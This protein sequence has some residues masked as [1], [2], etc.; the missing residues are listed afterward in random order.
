MWLLNKEVESYKCSSFNNSHIFPP[1]QRL[2]C[3][4]LEAIFSVLNSFLYVKYKIP[5]C[6]INARMCAHCVPSYNQ[7]SYKWSMLF[8]LH[9]SCWTSLAFSYVNVCHR[10]YTTYHSNVWYDNTLVQSSII[11][12]T[13]WNLLFLVIVMNNYVI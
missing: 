9:S 8:C 11:M 5:S 4:S 3:H 10:F 13:K 2:V 7:M 12:W 6:D 1:S